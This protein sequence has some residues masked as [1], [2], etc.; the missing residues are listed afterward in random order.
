MI[1]RIVVPFVFEK[2]IEKR[3]DFSKIVSITT[4]AASNMT[5]QAR[6]M[7]SELVR[8]VNQKCHTN[9][10]IGVDIHCLWCFDHR[11]KPGGPGL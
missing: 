9:M 6:G 2:L 11:F 4:D 1:E 5:G 7:A 3:Y 10:V 8:L